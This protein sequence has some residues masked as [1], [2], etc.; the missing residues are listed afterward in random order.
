[1]NLQRLVLGCMYQSHAVR[2]TQCSLCTITFRSG[3]FG[4]GLVTLSRH[5]ITQYGFWQYAAAGSA[6]AFYCGD[7]YATKGECM[8]NLPHASLQ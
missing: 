7:Y 6:F 3:T 4:A 1:M 8:P 5:A 2:P